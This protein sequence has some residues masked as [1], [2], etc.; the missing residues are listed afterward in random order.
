LAK[1]VSNVQ[2]INLLDE[3]VVTLRPASIKVLKKI[4]AVIEKLDSLEDGNQ[5]DVM[6][7]LVEA[8]AV[9]LQKQLPDVASFVDLD[10]KKDKEEYDKQR[11]EYEEM[12]DMDIVNLVNE[13]CGGIKF[14]DPN[15][16]LAAMEAAGEN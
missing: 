2:K 1:E 11:E 15:Q 3:T 13:V 4:M 10:P 9:A 14:N 16:V 7:I 8:S 12:V 6:D 5:N